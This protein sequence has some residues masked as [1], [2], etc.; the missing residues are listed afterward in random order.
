MKDL[1]QKTANL[2]SALTGPKYSLYIWLQTKSKSYT[3]LVGFTKCLIFH[4]LYEVEIN[5]LFTANLETKAQRKSNL[6]K[7]SQMENGKAWN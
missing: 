6:F 4:C 3:A 5:T 7:V 2:K 1:P